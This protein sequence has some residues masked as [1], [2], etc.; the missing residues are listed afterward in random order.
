MRLAEVVAA[1]NSW[2]VSGRN[3]DGENDFSEMQYQGV[4]I[5]AQW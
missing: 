4:P 5:V 1:E 3:P 2:V